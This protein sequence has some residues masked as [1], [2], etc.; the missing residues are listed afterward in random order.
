MCH[1][2]NKQYMHDEVGSFPFRKHCFFVVDCHIVMR[3]HPSRNSLMPLTC[4]LPSSVHALHL[5]QGMSL[6]NWFWPPVWRAYIYLFISNFSI[7]KCL[8]S[9]CLEHF[10]SVLC[11]DGHHKSHLSLLE[12]TSLQ[13]HNELLRPVG[14]RRHIV[15]SFTYQTPHLS[16]CNQPAWWC[17]AL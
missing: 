12:H 1:I 11:C 9:V 3:F 7:Q 4:C 14:C 10:A 17:P 15:G 13:T 5:Q 8:L 16:P 6:R 2:I